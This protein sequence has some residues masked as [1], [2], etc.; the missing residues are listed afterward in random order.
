MAPPDQEPTAR[1]DAAQ[2]HRSLR[3][4]ALGTALV[5][6]ASGTLLGTWVSRIPAIVKQLDVT[7]G[8]LGRALLALGIGSLLSMPVT[9][10]ICRRV[11]SRTWV[12][13]TAFVA[14]VVLGCV[15]LADNLVQLG[16]VLFGLGLVYGSWDVSMNV[17]GSAVDRRAGREW[18]PRY[19]A[20]W[21]LGSIAGAALGSLAARNDVPI[22]M[23]FTIAAVGAAV[24]T[25]VGLLG[26]VDERAD[27][28]DQGGPGR[29]KAGEQP[30]ERRRKRV[31]T[32][33]ALLLVG[34]LT[35]CASVIE[36]AAA[37][38]LALYL[39]TGRG[40]S[41]ASAALGYTVFATAMTVGRFLGTP[42]AGWLGRATAVRIGGFLGVAGV[43]L[44]VLSPWV[45]LTYAGALLWGAGICL[46]FPAA[47]SAAGETDRPAESIALVTSI[48]YG[49]ILVGPPLIGALADVVGMG[50]A[51]LTLAGLAAVV[52]ILAPVVRQ[53]PAAGAGGGTAG[54]SGETFDDGQPES[55]SIAR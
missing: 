20:C 1:Q 53:R 25:Y 35:L 26:Y 7:A 27:H 48:G 10:H 46:V 23:H 49:S 3:T 47:V 13:I 37:D 18:M 11:G 33:P 12:A 50:N 42:L 51:L 24:V 8:E 15:G 16:V 21:S 4:A 41:E 43:L 55:A 52:A 22:G 40:L 32:N 31:A 6:T 38:W 5:F 44:T 19:H 2:Q 17:Q 54:G 39:D 28:R 36:G 29:L 9:G 14:A 45:P 30:G 34:A